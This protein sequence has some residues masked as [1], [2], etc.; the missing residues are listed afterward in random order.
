[1][2]TFSNVKP[3]ELSR[4]FSSVR[5][6]EEDDEDWSDYLGSAKEKLT[7]QDLRDNPLSVVVGEAG[8]GKTVEFEL[9][10]QRLRGAGNPAFFV[11]LNQLVDSESWKLALVGSYDEYE[12]WKVSTET[13]YFLLDAVDEARLTSHAAFDRALSIV[14]CGLQGCMSRVRFVISSRPTDW[15]INDVRMAVDKH[16]GRPIAAAL[17]A[18]KETPAF[19]ISTDG[20]MPNVAR[21][22][23]AEVIE[24]LVVSLD[25]LSISEAKRLAEAFGVLDVRAFWDTVSDGGY[26]FMATRPLDLEWMVRLW[27]EKRSFGTY[28]ELIEFN[29]ENRLTEVNPSYHAAG[30]VLSQDQL[31]EG[32]EELAAVAELS[33]CAYIATAYVPTVK[34]DEVAPSSVLSDWKPIE[35]ARLLASAVFDEATYGRVRFHHRTIRAY[36]AACWLNRQLAIGVPFHHVL[37]LFSSSPFGTTV[38]IPNRR[39]ALCWLTAINVEAREWVMHHFPEML[40]FDGDPDA[41]DSPSADR[42]FNAYVKRLKGGLRTDWHNSESEFRRV[43]RKLSLGLVSDL[44]MSPELPAQVTIELLPIV[45]YGRLTDCAEAVFGVYKNIAADEDERGYALNVLETIATPQQRAAIKEDLVSGSLMSNEIIASALSAIDWSGLSADQLVAVFGVTESEKGY[46]PMTRTVKYVLLPVATATSAELLLRAV[47]EALP[48]PEAGKRFAQFPDSDQPERAWLLDVLPDCF[49]CLLRLLPQTYTNY[50]EICIEAAERLEALR[51]TGF[52]DR[53]EYR[54]IHALVAEHPGLRW[55]IALEIAKSKNITHSTSRLVWGMDCLV[56]FTVTDVSQLIARANDDTASQDVRNIWFT[57]GVDVVFQGLRGWAR[58]DALAAFVVG[59]DIEARRI[60]IATQRSNRIDGAKHRREWK[61]KKVAQ[62]HTRQIQHEKNRAQLLSDVDHIRDASHKGA[63]NWLVQYSYNV[64]RDSF[65]RVDYELIVKDFDQAVADALA[66]GLKVVWN[67]TEVLNPA[68]YSDGTVPWD[69]LYALA[70]LHTL[71][72]EGMEISSLS[73]TDA[74]RAAKLAVWEQNGPPDWFEPLATSHAA[75]VSEALRPWIESGAKLSTDAHRFRGGLAMALRCSDEVGAALLAP[76]LTM[77]KNKSIARPETL[78]EVVKTLRAGGLLAINALAEICRTEVI[79]SVSPNGLVGDM[80][81]LHT[82]L[83]EDV[84]SAWSWFE[85]HISSHEGVAGELIKAFAKLTQNCKWVKLPADAA[86]IDVLLRLHRLLTVHQPSPDD[87][88]DSEDMGTFGHVVSEL[89]SRIPNLLVQ[90]RGAVA[91]QALVELVMEETAPNAK[92]WLATQVTE[93]AVREA[94][95]SPQVELS[96]LRELGSPFVTDPKSEAQL[97]KQVI[98]RL[99]E[100]RKGTEEGPFSDRNL[101][102]PSMPEK[103]LQ[104]WL[105]ARFLDTKNRR[106]TV[107]RE[108][109]VDDNKEPDIQLGC[110]KGK[111]CVEIKPLSRDHSYSAN[112]LTDTLRTQI[113]S[114]YLKGFNSAHGILVLFRLDDKAWDIPDK[115][116]NQPFST[117]VEYLQE[118]ANLISAETPGVEALIVFGIDCVA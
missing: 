36:L 102:S 61:S 103:Y 81:W 75:A 33:G 20:T 6:L 8:I 16:L 12:N 104:S 7:W 48:K 18:L 5:N 91:H 43:S 1:M 45:K 57:V 49:E 85:E 51:D 30:A 118:Q 106:F 82:W 27:N 14:Q 78:K 71:L 73:D 39:W 64:G 62:K 74:G 97:F 34:A 13:A 42:A 21:M 28:L 92:Q 96:D 117:L 93:H 40:L 111:V 63:L 55:Q 47:L 99:E 80:H 26:E 109:E 88:F 2:N 69:V 22:S 35:V 3:I 44:L 31:R 90:S 77:V 67:T 87:S 79:A 100:V 86:S 23:T 112:S 37:T 58:N 110:S 9:E 25:P 17:S 60:H 11:A 101:F 29:I 84:V 56:S 66:A 10:V 105:A 41:W 89:R 24:P 38:L 114:Q 108:E 116:K 107:S 32:A 15:S 72:D 70:G 98:A 4:T 52:I 54:R 59:P 19:E 95:Q 53:E 113:M 65:T 115:A 50:P 76:L 83:E 68:D 46:G 94:S